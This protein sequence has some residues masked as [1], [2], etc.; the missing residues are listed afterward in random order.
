M[1]STILEN[2]EIVLEKIHHAAQS[3]GRTASDVRLVVVTKGQPLERIQTVIAAGARRL[4]ENYADEGVEKIRAISGSASIEWH[5]IGHVQSRKARL[6]CAHFDWMHSL[7]NLKLAERLDRF[8]GELGRK[9]PVLIECNVSGEESK[10]GY[11]AWQEGAWD[12]LARSIAPL[13]NFSN[14]QVQG[15]M[16]MAPYA[17]DPE[18]ARPY[19]RRLRRLRDELSTR[20]PALNWSE[21]S[22]GVSGDFETAV[23]EGATIVR[24]GEAILGPRPG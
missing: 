10:F 7:D 18:A 20:F 5:M 3:V 19:F 14:L 2:Y 22:M 8:S 16:T 13:L 9:L 24:I 15:L 17:D 12:D 6:V 11:P 21:L 4:G 1:A 23:Q